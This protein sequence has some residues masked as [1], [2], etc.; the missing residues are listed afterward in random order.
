M[1]LTFTMLETEHKI[2]V[3]IHND[4]I[5][6]TTEYLFVHLKTLS[7][8]TTSVVLLN[9]DRATVIIRSEDRML[10]TSV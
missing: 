1:N 7:S 9:P 5:V 4:D 3:P 10:I 8:T 6:E 2:T